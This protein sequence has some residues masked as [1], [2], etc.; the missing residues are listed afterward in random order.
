MQSRVSLGLAA[1]VFRLN[2]PAVS[3]LSST[4]TT[5]RSRHVQFLA[6]LTVPHIHRDNVKLADWLYLGNSRAYLIYALVTVAWQK[7]GHRKNQ[8][9]DVG[10]GSAR[11]T[12]QWHTE[13]A[14]V[15]VTAKTSWPTRVP[16][17]VKKVGNLSGGKLLFSFSRGRRSL[18]TNIY[19]F[20][21]S[22]LGELHGRYY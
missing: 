18:K 13:V 2:Q 15:L 16:T 4:T 21:F 1:Y 20:L 22:V 9:E 8:K 3:S 6:Q 17:G 12:D 19:L 14:T 5:R 10:E 11:M 7:L